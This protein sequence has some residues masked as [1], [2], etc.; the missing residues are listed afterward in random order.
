MVISR[1]YINECV[2]SN[3]CHAKTKSSLVCSAFSVRVSGLWGRGVKKVLVLARKQQR[4]ALSNFS[5]RY[6]VKSINLIVC[7]FCSQ[8]LRRSGYSIINHSDL[9]P[10]PR[11]C[12]SPA[13][14]T[15]VRMEEHAKN[16]VDRSSSASV[17]LD[18]VETTVQVCSFQ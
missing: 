7:V 15:R 14:P 6:P 1:R 5:E 11:K 17:K 10:L 12:P 8:F 2:T 16:L 18:L 4:R 3:P 13:V 9:S